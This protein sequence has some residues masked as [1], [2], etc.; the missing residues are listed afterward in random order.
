MSAN[1]PQIIKI[2]TKTIKL[3]GPQKAQNLRTLAADSPKPKIDHILRHVAQNAIFE[4]TESTRNCR[5]L[6][7]SAPQ[8]CPKRPIDPRT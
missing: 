7:V 3:K 5:L 1:R 6:V 2:K 4:R 8:N